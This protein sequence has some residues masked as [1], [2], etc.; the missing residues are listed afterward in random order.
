MAPSAVGLSGDP[1]LR[2]QLDCVHVRRQSSL[3][4]ELAVQ[5]WNPLRKGAAQGDDRVVDLRRIQADIDVRIISASRERHVRA[6]RLHRVPKSPE[7][8]QAVLWNN[9]FVISSGSIFTPFLLTAPAR[10]L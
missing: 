2:Q 6:E 7:Q 4:F 3:Q 1:L 8:S 5:C 10:R 9:D